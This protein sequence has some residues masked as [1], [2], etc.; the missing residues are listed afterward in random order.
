[1]AAT[2]EDPGDD[3]ALTLEKNDRSAIIQQC[4][5]R[6]SPTH[7]EIIDLVYYH[8]KSVGEVA[9]IAAAPE[10]TVKT[11]M[12]YARNH[13]ERLLEKAG[14]DRA[15]LKTGG[16]RIPGPPLRRSPH[17]MQSLALVAQGL[18]GQRALG[19]PARR[20]ERNRG[21]SALLVVSTTCAIPSNL[22]APPPIVRP[23]TSLH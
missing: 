5:A 20:W 2:I 9:Q 13:I 6:L 7:R 16:S 19:T 18:K 3:P 14:I 21:G 1:M 15:C 22:S 10:S 12:F 8:E 11:R 17:P 23:R 4:L